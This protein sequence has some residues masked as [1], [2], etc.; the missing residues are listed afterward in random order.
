MGCKF[1]ISVVHPSKS[2]KKNSPKRVSE[3][4]IQ[5]PDPPDDEITNPMQPL[6]AKDSFNSFELV[7]PDADIG[8]IYKGVDCK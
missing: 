1:S 3:K 4:E 2:P 7:P 5:P 8:C 6:E